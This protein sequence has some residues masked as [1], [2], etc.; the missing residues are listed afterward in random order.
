VGF[1]TLHSATFFPIAPVYRK[2]EVK[3]MYEGVVLYASSLF[4]VSVGLLFTGV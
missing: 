4:S 2:E 3:H 1:L